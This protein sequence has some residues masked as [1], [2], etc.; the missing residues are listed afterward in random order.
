MTVRATAR[1]TNHAVLRVTRHGGKWLPMPVTSLAESP[2]VQAS[3]RATVA[4]ANLPPAAPPGRVSE[5]CLRA[6]AIWTP[7]AEPIPRALFALQADDANRLRRD[8][9][10]ALNCIASGNLAARA[11][12]ADRA[13]RE[14]AGVSYV[15]ATSTLT[16]TR[17]VLVLPDS[18]AT[19]VWLGVEAILETPE[20]ARR[21]GRCGA[22]GCGK[23][24][25]ALEGKK[26][27]HCS[28]AH[29]QAAH[30][31]RD[32]VRKHRQRKRAL[33]ERVG[34]PAVP[35]RRGRRPRA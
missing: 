25:L 29:C 21:L 2:A 15:A 18:P 34:A 22:P 13:G 9:H 23:F 33:A 27:L 26:R 16:R 12:L 6:G 1:Q 8:A 32:R 10:E 35:K 5:A 20:L 30:N 24:N 19:A 17:D 11:A 31:S 3:V 14:L 28:Q 4:V 7:A